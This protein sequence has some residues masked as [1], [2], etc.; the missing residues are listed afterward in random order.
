MAILKIINKILF[1]K[2]LGLFCLVVWDI[3]TEAR[4]NNKKLSDKNISRDQQEAEEAAADQLGNAKRVYDSREVFNDLKKAIENISTLNQKSS[5]FVCDTQKL[6]DQF[7]SP[8]PPEISF[9]SRG[10]KKCQES[11]K[12]IFQKAEI[13]INLAIGYHDGSQGRSKDRAF[14]DAF[15][16]IAQRSCKKEQPSIQLCGFQRESS[17]EDG[18]PRIYSKTFVGVDGKPHKM[19]FSIMNSSY[20]DSYDDNVGRDKQK[21]EQRSAQAEK[22]FTKSL[23]EADFVFYSGHSRAGGGPDFRPP[24]Y[25]NISDKKIDYKKYKSEKTGLKQ[26]VDAFNERDKNNPLGALGIFSCSSKDHFLKPL[27]KLAPK[28]AFIMTEE[29]SAFV[30]E[31]FTVVSAI[32]GVM[33]QMCEKDLETSMKESGARK[34]TGREFEVL[35]LD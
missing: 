10:S 25:K 34:D 13:K 6:K 24:V 28:S 32:N 12:R 35:G 18:G 1:F 30:D 15:S 5:G 16:R 27:Q 4:N 20:S 21:Q 19:I 14:A 23:K 31:A 22:F 7:G 2:F 9:A 11:Y 29:P 17:G 33:S 26:M 3:P 8:I